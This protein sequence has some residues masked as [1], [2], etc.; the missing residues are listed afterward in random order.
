[1]SNQIR[2][3]DAVLALED[4]SIFRGFSFGAKATIMGEAVFNTGMTGIRKL[5]PIPP[6][7]AKLLP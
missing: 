4:G 3:R 5:S 6:T 2:I 7:L 1:M